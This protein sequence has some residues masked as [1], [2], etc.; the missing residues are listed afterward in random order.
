MNHATV[1][2]NK[3]HKLKPNIEL[4]I[5]QNLDGILSFGGP[6]SNHLHALAWACKQHGLNSTGLVRGELHQTLTPTLTDCQNW[7]M[8]LIP[9]ERTAY[10]EIQNQL[11]NEERCVSQIL[12]LP[13]VAENLLVVPEGGSNSIAIA[14]LQKAYAPIF[15]QPQYK[16]VTHAICATGSGATVAGLYKAA[17]KGIKVIGV[18]AVAEGQATLRRVRRWIGDDLPNLSIVPGHLGGFAKM[19]KELLTFIDNFEAEQGIPLDPIYNGK[20]VYKISHLATQ[21]FFNADDK[22]LIVHTGGLQG[23][24]GVRPSH[25]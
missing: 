7:G 16:R 19:P 14:S 15:N 3:L 25:G 17:P 5:K 23:K 11:L 10:R 24:R 21:N 2:G 20:V 4:A 22:V 12:C 13:E 6:Y 1:S 8:Q 9:I 18:Q